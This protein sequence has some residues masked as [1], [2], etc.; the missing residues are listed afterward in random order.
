MVTGGQGTTSLTVTRAYELIQGVQ[1]AYDFSGGSCTMEPVAT[2]GYLAGL[3]GGGGTD[4]PIGDPTG[5]TTGS[6]VLALSADAVA[7]TEFPA[8]TS[9]MAFGLA[10]DSFP[11][12]VFDGSGDIY[13]GDGTVDPT[14]NPLTASAFLHNSVLGVLQLSGSGGC[15]LSDTGTAGGGV[16]IASSSG[17][18]QLWA[19]N[20]LSFNDDSTTGISITESGSGPITINPG[21]GIFISSLPTSDPL[22]AGQ[23]WNSSGVLMVS[24][25]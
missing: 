10:G 7:W 12:V 1:T 13:F 23:L 8:N 25:G 14:A 21:G 24:A 9:A 19:G 4:V 16:F 6:T 22:V 18:V 5:I 3:G 17:P 20:G 11:R 15:A 2:S